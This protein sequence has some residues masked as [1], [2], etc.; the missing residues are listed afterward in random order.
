MKNAKRGF[1]S[2]NPKKHEAIKQELRRFRDIKSKGL[3]TSN[4]TICLNK[5][6]N[7]TH[8][9]EKN[10]KIEGLS[11]LLSPSIY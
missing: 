3:Q 11:N 9:N 1:N 5:T 4:T 7:S 2:N 10:K 8:I 6:N